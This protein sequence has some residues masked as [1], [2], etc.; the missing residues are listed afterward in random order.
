MPPKNEYAH[1]LVRFS[2]EWGIGVSTAYFALIKGSISGHSSG[3]APY[4]MDPPPAEVKLGV[5]VDR[6]FAQAV[7]KHLVIDPPQTLLT[8][9]RPVRPRRIRCGNDEL[10][11]A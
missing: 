1:S 8:Q 7:D 2:P 9:R 4:R 3:P 5:A 6:G 10:W 11:A